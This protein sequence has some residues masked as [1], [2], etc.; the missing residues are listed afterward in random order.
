M[1]LR[2]CPTHG[3]VTS[4]PCR[5]C[6]GREQGVQ[7]AREREDERRDLDRR[8]SRKRER[9]AVRERMADSEQPLPGSLLE[10]WLQDQP[11]NPFGANFPLGAPLREDGESHSNAWRRILRYDP[12]SYC[13]APLSGT[14][15]HIQP[16]SEGRFDRERWVN[17]IGACERCNRSKSSKPMLFYLLDR[18][19]L[20][21]RT[22]Q[23]REGKPDRSRLEAEE[24]AKARINRM[25]RKVRE[26][27]R[28]WRAA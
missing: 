10:V 5:E 17:L 26:R 14:V 6:L 2:T 16:K 3:I 20:A 12:C 18:L 11:G 23:V 28:S 22:E 8:Y 15:D 27:E 21:V 19:T 7:R 1:S 13:G 24:I 4:V 25:K 9:D